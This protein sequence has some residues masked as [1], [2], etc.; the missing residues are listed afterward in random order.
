MRNKWYFHHVYIQFTETPFVWLQKYNLIHHSSL[1]SWQKSWS[2]S[3]VIAS[4]QKP[5]S[6]HLLSV[7]S[8][9]FHSVLDLFESAKAWKLPT[10]FTVSG[11]M[12]YRFRSGFC[13]LIILV[14]VS[15][16]GFA[17]V[18]AQIQKP[19]NVQVAVRAKWSGTPLLLEAGY[20]FVLLY[21]FIYNWKF[22]FVF[23]FH[24]MIEAIVW[25][26]FWWILKWVFLVLLF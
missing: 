11:Q 14:C 17:S 5:H 21:S 4:A 22:D 1:Y 3:L 23:P 7:L 9:Q 24:L 13:V 15:L 16:C 18:C 20:V 8:V 6:V 10:C 19:K 25:I 26:C 12:E 2:T